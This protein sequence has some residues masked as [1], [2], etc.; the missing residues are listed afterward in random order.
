MVD[1]RNDAESRRRYAVQIAGQIGRVA[2]LR[3]GT[4]R[5]ARHAPDGAPK[6]AVASETGRIEAFSDGVFAIAI[7]LLV[8]D[9]HV[10]LRG[11]LSNQSLWSALGDRWTNYLSFL[12]SFL[13][14]AV[15]WANHRTMFIFIRRADH[16]LVVLN[17][18]LLLNVV[19][20]PFCAAL[21]GEYIDVPRERQ[22]ALIIY[23]GALVVGGIFYNALW[24]HAAHDHRLLHPDIDPQLIRRL[25]GRYLMGPILYTVAL[26][27]AFLNGIASLV[28]CWVLALLYLLPSFAHDTRRAL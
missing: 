17:T 3:Q 25:S 6:S 26:G 10:P 7:T 4:E 2:A 18:L 1:G 20:L 12:M 9:V 15:V 11:D 14:V 13:I 19:T 21:L 24:R 27:L 8:L 28:A 22:T 23:T 5:D 16:A